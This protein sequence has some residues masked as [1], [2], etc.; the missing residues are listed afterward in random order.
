MP[1]KVQC[2]RA[3]VLPN[4]SAMPLQCVVQYV[5]GRARLGL[6]PLHWAAAQGHLAATRALLKWGASVTVRCNLFLEDGH[7]VGVGVCFTVRWGAGD[8]GAALQSSAAAKA[9]AGN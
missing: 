8:E 7:Q 5:D 9:L 6:A 1:P 2:Q 3:N 4:P